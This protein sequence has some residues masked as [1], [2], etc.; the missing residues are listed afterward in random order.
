MGARKIL[1]AY[2]IN[3]KTSDLNLA[4]QIARRIRASSGGFPY[5]KALGLPLISRNLVQVSM[6]LTDFE[7]TPLHVVYEEVSRL[8]AARG[9]RNRG[10]RIDRATAKVRNGMAFAHFTK[11][12][13]FSSR[14]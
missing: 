12:S 10:K 6:N 13:S 14:R 3:L 9:S 4:K 8:A 5:V 7:Q 2:N 11:L 1:I